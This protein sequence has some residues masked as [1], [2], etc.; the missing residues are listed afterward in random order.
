MHATPLYIATCMHTARPHVLVVDFSCLAFFSRPP[1]F[2]PF[3]FLCCLSGTCAQCCKSR[4]T[5]GGG[6][7]GCWITRGQRRPFGPTHIA[8][9][10]LLTRVQC[11]PCRPLLTRAR[12]PA[13]R[14]LLARVRCLTHRP[15][16]T[17]V[18]CLTH[19]P[20]LMRVRCLAHR[21]LLTWVRCLTHRPLLA[22]ERHLAHRPLLTWVRRL[23]HTLYGARTHLPRGAPCTL[24]SAA[25]ALTAPPLPINLWSLVW[26]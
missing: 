7:G 2:F 5:S 4:N 24:T 22:R 8:H 12:R 17:W 11:L 26:L 1:S 9:R 3:P 13:R 6:G 23:T 25:R 16:L 14:P 19:R 18:R 10:P 15:L 21:P 20:L